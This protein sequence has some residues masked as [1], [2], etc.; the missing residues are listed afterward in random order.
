MQSVPGGAG[1]DLGVAD[2]GA[3]VTLAAVVVLLVASVATGGSSQE[4][5]TGQFLTVLLSLPAIAW[6]FHR[7]LQQR[8]RLPVALWMTLAALVLAI[9]AVQLLPLPTGL[10]SAG[11]ARAQL[12]SDLA[13]FGAQAPARW[14]LASAATALA[15]L[16]MLP[17]LAVFLLCLALPVGVLPRVGAAIVVLAVASLVLGIVQLGAPQESLVNPYPQWQPAMN[18][19]FANPNHQ[20]TLLV[21][22]AIFAATW[23][24]ASLDAVRHRQ[25]VRPAL[26]LAAVFVLLLVC[27][28]IPLTGSRAGVII[29]VVAIA[30]VAVWQWPSMRATLAGRLMVGLAAAAMCLGIWAAARWMQVDAV[31]E[32]RAPMRDATAA[33]AGTFAPLGSGVGSYVPVFEQAAPPALLMGNYVNHAHNEYLQWWLEAGVAGLLA[34]LLALVALV[35]TA[36]GILRL[37]HH[38]RGAGL[39]ALVSL[40]AIAAHSVVDY[41]LR[42]PA[43]LAVAAALAGI[44]AGEAGRAGARLRWDR[45]GDGRQDGARILS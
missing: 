45:A 36:R 15:L 19:F 18:G 14:S 16:S 24:M 10:A 9:P 28:A 3:R 32:L 11:P 33:L 37:P 25:R 44:A 35:T 22:A 8:R 2:D 26:T 13:V 21:V 20:A 31:D 40:L 27:V 5:G 43:M 29:L 41:P 17:A 23:L 7:L 34:M 42:T 6:A 39:A 4:A 38:Q 1:T 30:A 12:A